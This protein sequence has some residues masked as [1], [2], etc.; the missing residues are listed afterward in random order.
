MTKLRKS[1]QGE[2][3]TL[4]IPGACNNNPETTVLCHL[5]EFGH[6]GMGLKPHD[7]AGV[8]ACDAC[9]AVLD[10]RVINEAFEHERYWFISRALIATHK[11]MMEKGVL[12]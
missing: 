1:A 8:F 11:R 2:A 6:G 12:K 10:R 9:H 5:R 7:I 3:C 4:G